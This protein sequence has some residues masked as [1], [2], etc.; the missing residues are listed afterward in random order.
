VA[1]FAISTSTSGAS[2]PPDRGYQNNTGD[3]ENAL[4][5]LTTTTHNTADSSGPQVAALGVI[6]VVDSTGDGDNV[7]QVN[8]VCDDGTGHCTLRAAIEVSN[9]HV[10]TDAIVFNIPTTDPGFSNGTWTINLPRALPDIFDAVN[11]GGPGPEQLVVQRSSAFGTP[12]FRVFSV[13]AGGTMNISGLT[14]SNGAPFSDTDGNGGGINYTGNGTLNIRKCTLATNSASVDGGGIANNGG[15]LNIDDSTL[16]NNGCSFNGG[17]IFNNAGTV[18]LTNSTLDSNSSND[19]GGIWNNSGA[20]V[21]ITNCTLE[22]S[23][24]SDGGGIFNSG[25]LTLL[26]STLKRNSGGVGRWHLE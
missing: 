4:N 7:S 2:P 13:S 26:R 23:T 17:G 3:G 22:F 9:S 15:T 16:V 20:T 8:T 5:L 18:N 11:I 25:T 12:D 21:N 10:G 19:G 24:T 14:V 6:Y 1:W